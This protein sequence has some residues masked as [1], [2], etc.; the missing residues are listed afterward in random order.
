MCFA[1]KTTR[2]R[3]TS[4]AA[5]R[6]VTRRERPVLDHRDDERP[7]QV[8]ACSGEVGRAAFRTLHSV[9]YSS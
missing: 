7:E 4:S 8:G 5:R 3:A 6:K 1:F 2:R 9:S